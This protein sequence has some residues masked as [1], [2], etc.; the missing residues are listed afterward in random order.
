MTIGGNLRG[1]MLSECESPLP[2]EHIGLSHC[3][4]S[5]VSMVTQF[6]AR[7]RKKKKYNLTHQQQA[8]HG[9]QHKLRQKK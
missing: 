9:L 5:H 7:I 1:E 4:N 8:R 6:N 3:I 2:I